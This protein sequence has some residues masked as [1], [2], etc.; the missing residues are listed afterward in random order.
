MSAFSPEVT[1]ALTQVSNLLAYADD[2]ATTLNGSIIGA[3]LIGTTAALVIVFS[4][5]AK[6]LQGKKFAF[7]LTPEEEAAVSAYVYADSYCTIILSQSLP[8]LTFRATILTVWM[9]CSTPRRRTRR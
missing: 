4:L 5:L 2:K 3:S 9:T 6:N 7:D 8:F 1:G